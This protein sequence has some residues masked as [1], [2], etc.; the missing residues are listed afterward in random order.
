MKCGSEIFFGVVLVVGVIGVLTLKVCVSVYTLLGREQYRVEHVRHKP[1]FWDVRYYF[2]LYC[3]W[4]DGRVFSS[5][6]N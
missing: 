2:C 5:Q 6:Q 4:R 1:Q 3:A